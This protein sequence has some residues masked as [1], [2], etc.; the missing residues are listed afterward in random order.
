MIL[1]RNDGRGGLNR[2]SAERQRAD[3]ERR[4]QE[5]RQTWWINLSHLLLGDLPPD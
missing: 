2:A 1:V 5:E 4:Q 3:E